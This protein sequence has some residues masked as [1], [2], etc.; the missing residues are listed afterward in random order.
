MKKAA[1]N[2]RKRIIERGLDALL[3]G[4]IHDEGQLDCSAKDA[5]EVGKECVDAIR[6]A[7]LD[8]GFKVPLTGN[9][10]IGANWAECH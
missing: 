2:A 5:E 9:Y 3:I 4:T 1:I 6:S 7:G 10:V 8:L